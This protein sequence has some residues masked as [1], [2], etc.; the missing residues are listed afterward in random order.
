MDNLF[1]SLHNELGGLHEH[2]RENV[3]D[4][5][6]TR[7]NNLQQSFQNNM[8]ALSSQFETLSTSHNIHALDQRQQQLQNDFS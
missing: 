1:D 8:G 2:I 5:I 6:M 7:M 4:S 3:H